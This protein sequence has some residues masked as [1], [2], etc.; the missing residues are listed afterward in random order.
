MGT[1]VAILALVV[2]LQALSFGACALLVPGWTDKT[3]PVRRT[4][5]PGDGV[6]PGPL[7]L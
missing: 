6:R 3:L 5:Q 1:V 4:Y 7:L 2:A